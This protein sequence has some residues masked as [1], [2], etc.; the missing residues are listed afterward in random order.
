M[1][2]PAFP[3]LRRS[4]PL[5]PS[6]AA[7]WEM[8]EGSDTTKFNDIVS[9]VYNATI[10]NT[11]MLSWIGTDAGWGLDWPGGTG[12]GRAVSIPSLTTGTTFSLEA[13]LRLRVVTAGQYGSLLTDTGGNAGF[14][15][16][17]ANVNYYF[18]GDHLN[19]TALTAG[20]WYHVVLSVNAGAGQWY[21]NGVPDGTIA[22][23]TTQTLT[24]MFQD[25]GSEAFQGTLS[26]MRVWLN[27][28]LTQADAEAQ[29]A[30][31][32]ELVRPKRTILKAS[33]V[34]ASL[35]WRRRRFIHQ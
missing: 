7:A 34:V 29:N 35:L 19:N 6:L 11:T 31:Q 24:T 14:F 13:R 4:H 33:A 12:G 18:G 15:R 10:L 20:L 26:F 16:K 3:N 32:W 25:S 30:D 5:A 8:Y 23:V 2:K 22:S 9:G 17:G 1:L 21:L 27:R 28:A